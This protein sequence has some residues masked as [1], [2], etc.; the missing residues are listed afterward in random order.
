MENKVLEI[1]CNHERLVNLP[2]AYKK[3]FAA[4]IEALYAD[5]YPK[6][7]VE[8]AILHKDLYIRFGNLSDL[9]YF[10]SNLPENKK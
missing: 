3:M 1:I 2:F 9:Q 10:W 4:E 5:Y 7:F 8:W 6:G